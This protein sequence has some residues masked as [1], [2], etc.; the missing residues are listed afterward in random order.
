MKIFVKNLIGMTKTFY[1]GSNDTVE[2]LKLKIYE[3]DH[4]NQHDQR[5]IY[6]FWQLED[7]KLL[8]HY[9]IIENSTIHLCIRLGGCDRKCYIRNG[10]LCKMCYS[11]V[12]FS[13][14]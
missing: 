6:S 2:S 3:T 12:I 13:I 4:I 5:L 9:N 10:H 1:V 8:S 14:L 7:R 11:K